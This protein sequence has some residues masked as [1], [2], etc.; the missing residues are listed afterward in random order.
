MTLARRGQ[1]CLALMEVILKLLERVV[2]SRINVVIDNNSMLRREQYG[3]IN[4][5]QIQDPII[6]LVERIEDA[7]VT[8]KELHILA[9]LL[10]SLTY[11]RPLTHW[12]TGH[13]P[14][15]G[16]RSAHQKTW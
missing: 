16:G 3:G 13:K 12:S 6:I 9:S 2:F 10:T 11:Q 14:C 4:G 1:Y 15:R 7:N 5:R 8:K